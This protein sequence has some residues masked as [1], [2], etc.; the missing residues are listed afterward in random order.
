[1]NVIFSSQIEE[2]SSY[3]DYIKDT[4]GNQGETITGLP[5]GCTITYHKDESSKLSYLYPE[6]YWTDQHYLDWIQEQTNQIGVQA[7]HEIKWWS[8]LRY[9]CTLVKKDV[10]FWNELM[11]HIIDF[12]E[13]VCKYKQEGTE[14]LKK[15]IQLKQPKKR[16]SFANLTECMI[17]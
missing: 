6:L 7:I 4:N 13:K 17:D 8:I 9:E 12:S 11:P 3:E 15:Q 14:E 1:M 16:T 5:K 2:Y 10:K